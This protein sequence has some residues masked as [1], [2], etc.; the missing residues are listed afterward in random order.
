M[1]NKL[2]EVWEQEHSAQ[3]GFTA[4]HTLKPSQAVPAF[5]DFLIQSG[6]TPAE[7]HILDMGCGKGRNSVYLATRGF[8]VTGTD[9]SDKALQD[10]KQR[11]LEYPSLIQYEVVDL[12]KEWPFG[13]NHFD[14]IID[15]NTSIYIPDKERPFAIGEANRVLKP[16]GYYLFYG[17]A[18][19]QEAQ[20]AVHQQNNEDA[21]ANYQIGRYSEKHYN[22]QELRAAYSAFEVASLGTIQTSDR[23]DGKDVINTLWVGVFR[24][25]L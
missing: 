18:A 24:K 2:K 8:H 21:S 19:K 12:V 7:T 17:I 9:F 14:A 4:M 1:D 5:T 11:S 20:P 3:K 10:A 22:E 15:C 6:F 25:K 13:N 23:M 16:G